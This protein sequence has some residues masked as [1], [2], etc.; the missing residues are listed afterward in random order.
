M[1]QINNLLLKLNIN[2]P[3]E[4]ILQEYI[5]YMVE[6]IL[7]R[8]Y[9]KTKICEFYD[10][11]TFCDDIK[12]NPEDS[13]YNFYSNYCMSKI[14]FDNKDSSIFG[15]D[16]EY[17]SNNVINSKKYVNIFWNL[18]TKAKDKSIEYVNIVNK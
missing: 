4:N 12:N 9:Y 17:L 1:D 2:N 13:I 5:K 6:A 18:V 14:D 16:T 7:L 10:I 15:I 8:Q 11:K 3:K